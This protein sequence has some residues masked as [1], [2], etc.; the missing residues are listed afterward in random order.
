MAQGLTL[1]EPATQTNGGGLNASASAATVT[2]ANPIP[3]GGKIQ[4]NFLFGVQAGNPFSAL[5]GQKTLAG[6]SNIILAQQALLPFRFI[7]EAVSAAPAIVT[8][9]ATPVSGRVLTNKGSGISGAVV[10]VTGKDGKTV[11]ATTNSFGYYQ[12]KNLNAGETYV[13]A[14]TAKRYSFAPQVVQISQELTD[15]NFIGR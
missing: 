11:N 2:F 5:G 3:V 1:E 4:V 15:L 9:A 13:F 7:A 10:R 6:K 8:A 14:V 12:V